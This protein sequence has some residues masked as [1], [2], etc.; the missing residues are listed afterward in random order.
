M[1]ILVIQKLIG[2]FENK[3]MSKSIMYKNLNMSKLITY[4]YN[5]F[6]VR[7]ID[8]QQLQTLHETYNS[9]PRWDT[10]SI[11]EG[12]PPLRTYFT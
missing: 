12:N 10:I 7:G 1:V 5:L 9:V 2:Q 8:R 6:T 3:Y 4:Y 11:S